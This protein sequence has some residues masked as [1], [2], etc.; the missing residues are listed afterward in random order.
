ML[1]K[2]N[3]GKALLRRH[4]ITTPHGYRVET[5][6]ELETAIAALQFP[7]VLKVQIASGARGKNGGILF[8][9][10]AVEAR[11]HYSA[12]M[13]REINGHK[14]SALLV[15]RKLDFQKERYLGLIVYEHDI[16][17]M[18]A[19]DG[20]VDIEDTSKADPKHMA[21][22]TLNAGVS[23]E[24]AAIIE[25]FVQQG[26]PAHLHD[27]YFDVCRR[28]EELFIASD[29]TMAEINPLVELANGEL[30]AVDARI[31]IDANGLPRQEQLTKALGFDAGGAKK[32][33]I[34]R[35]PHL[36]ILDN[37]GSVGLIGLGGG[38]NLTV[39]DWL[40]A[41]GVPA[42][43]VIDID[44]AIGTG[45]TVPTVR[46]IIKE[47]EA[48]DSAKAILVN[49]IS[50]GYEIDSIATDI[51]AAVT[52]RNEP[53]GLPIILHLQGN[54]GPQAQEILEN[55]GLKN[56]GSLREAIAMVAEIAK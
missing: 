43:A 15:E 41:E 52:E 1:L 9:D 8:A 12:L 37:G 19:A 20:G 28:L 4:G 48:I 16:L 49:I 47:I 55:A 34:R 24:K 56:C 30:I 7:V 17:L 50:C 23:G 45:S 29:A 27:R 32:T 35:E 38:L 42:A 33:K 53:G 36:S 6:E 31:D 18:I 11:R 5:P 21:L 54:R 51:V 22:I 2:E 46:Q 39:F 26:L 3:E 13:G 25:A 40:A 14:V 10:T 44:D